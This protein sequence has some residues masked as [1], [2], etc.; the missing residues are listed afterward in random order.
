MQNIKSR[1]DEITEEIMEIKKSLIAKPLDK[2]KTR[3]AWLDMKKASKD[4]SKR[5]KG[6]AAVK[7]IKKQRTK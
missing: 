1:L 3:K 5:W 2:K 6:P 7:E 4:I